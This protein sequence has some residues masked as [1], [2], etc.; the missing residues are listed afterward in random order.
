MLGVKR[1]LSWF[2]LSQQQKTSSHSLTRHPSCDGKENQNKKAKFMGWN[3]DS[4]TEQQRQKIITIIILIKR[5]Y[6]VHF[7]HR[8]TL[9]LLQSRKL[10]SLAS[11]P[12]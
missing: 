5:T 10:P 4:L 9:S 11:S 7:S 2:S 12:T 6:R 3:K 8:L 1:N